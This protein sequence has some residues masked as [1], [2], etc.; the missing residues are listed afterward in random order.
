MCND[1]NSLCD[2]DIDKE[3]IIND[4]EETDEKEVN[5]ENA[6][7]VKD[8]SSKTKKATNKRKSKSKKK[9]KN[10]K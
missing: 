10:K 7:E 1:E 5:L 9:K 6:S 2:C 3:V 8:V 4:K